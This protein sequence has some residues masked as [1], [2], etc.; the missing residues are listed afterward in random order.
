MPPS[1]RGGSL[2]ARRAL[3]PTHLHVP[4]YVETFGRASGILAAER[5]PSAGWPDE[6]A[7]QRNRTIDA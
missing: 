2:L 5:S 6:P 4:E 7:P 3:E 1:L